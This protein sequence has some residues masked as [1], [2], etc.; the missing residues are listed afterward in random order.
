[1]RSPV[2]D[3]GRGLKLA[4]LL[5]GYLAWKVYGTIATKIAPTPVP[6]SAPSGNL[7]WPGTAQPASPGQPA[8]GI[9][10]PAFIDDRV[11][12]IPRVSNV[13]ESAPAYDVSIH[14][15]HR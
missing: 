12:F 6:A 3:G 7:P 8:D 15:R 11:D 5:V 13:P 14:A 4:V 9:A 1:M 10:K 2:S